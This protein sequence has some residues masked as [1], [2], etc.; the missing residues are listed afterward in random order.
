MDAEVRS[1]EPSRRG[2]VIGLMLCVVAIAFE[3]SA[4]V[5][6]MPAAAADLGD[7]P[8]YAWTFTAFMIAQV[9]AIVAAGL[10]SDQ[11]GPKG[12]LMIGF[13]VFA[14]GLVI[15]GS[16]PSMLA[17]VVGRFVQGLGGGTMNLAVMVLIARLFDA[18]ERAV[19]ITWMSVAWM[20]PAFIGPSLAAWLSSALSW[21][22][23]FF[24]VLPVMALGGLLIF[25]PLRRSKVGPAE[26]GID[27]AEAGT[28]RL[29]S[30]VLVSLGAAALQL[31]GQQLDLWSLA[32][33]AAALVLLGFGLPALLPRGYRITGSGLAATVNVRILATGAFF[34]VDTFLPLMLVRS[35]QLSLAWAG[36]VM[37][38]G[39]LGWTAGSWLQS[40][41]WFRLRR[42]VIASIGAACTVAGLLLIAV[43]VW[44]PGSLLGLI[45]GAWVLA[46]LGMGLHMA[47]TSLVVMQLSPEPEIGRNTSSLQLGEALG[48]SVA[49]G[50]AGTIFAAAL[51]DQKLAFG[52]AFAAMA[53]ISVLG[54]LSALRIGP[55]TNHSVDNI[56]TSR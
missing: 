30:A 54:L 9:F 40:R 32:W 15:A 51:S 31:A 21:H 18:K 17:L 36:V 12:P 37:T 28:H 50:V 26:G 27:S 24:S 41:P 43:A 20:L 44:F 35:E 6:A 48:N 8:L 56:S 7:L 14:V 49:A 23:V 4:V 29:R 46:G 39:S 42:D 34:G 53:A 1:T 38:I 3:A 5:T 19:L 16:A 52:A 13:I 11:R 47:S 55:V 25:G 33:V 2:L 45:I 10:A 22:W